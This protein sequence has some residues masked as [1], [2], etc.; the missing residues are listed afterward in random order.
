MKFVACRLERQPVASWQKLNGDPVDEEDK[1]RF[2]VLIL[3]P[4]KEIDQFYRVWVTKAEGLKACDMLRRS[5]GENST[6]TITIL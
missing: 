1:Q 2:M 4:A 3:H 6:R 5:F